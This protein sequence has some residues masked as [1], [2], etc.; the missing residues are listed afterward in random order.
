MWKGESSPGASSMDQTLTTSFSNSS[1]VATSVLGSTAN[2][3]LIDVL[4]RWIDVEV[5]YVFR[6]RDRAARVRPIANTADPAFDRGARKQHVGLLTRVAEPLQVRDGGATGLPKRERRV[7]QT[8][9]PIVVD[10][11]PLECQVATS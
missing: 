6:D 8:L 4:R 9:A 1:S 11:K 5:K 2:R 10:R 7:E 3:L